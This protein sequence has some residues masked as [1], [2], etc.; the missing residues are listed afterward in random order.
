MILLLIPIIVTGYFLLKINI[1]S[2]LKFY[3]YDGKHLYIG[4]LAYG[5]VFTLA[6]ILIVGYLK[7]YK[8]VEFLNSFE[9][10]MIKIGESINPLYSDE[11]TY[12]LTILAIAIILV[13]LWN[14]LHFFV[15]WIKFRYITHIF[16][17][18]Q[19]KGFC[20]R[21]QIKIF[22]M[23]KVLMD[24][25]LDYILL[26]A[27]VTGNLLMLSMEDRKVYVGRIISLGEPTDS[28][29]LSQEVSIIP[30]YSGYRNIDTLKLSIDIDDNST[31]NYQEFGQDIYL[32]LRQENIVSATEFDVHAYKELNPKG[33]D[34]TSK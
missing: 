12:T 8:C 32:T 7:A 9:V 3:R 5:G 22:L 20:Y 24:S 18:K 10:F 15:Y 19:K 26:N 11:I 31:T 1:I 30:I 28:R 4:I 33:I 2:S 29:V 14:L 6:A 25:P 27:F 23:K 17:I 21:D 16:R 13:F 34:K